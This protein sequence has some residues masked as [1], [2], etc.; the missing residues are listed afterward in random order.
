MYGVLFLYKIVEYLNKN[1]SILLHT[2]CRYILA[3]KIITISVKKKKIH[4]SFGP[5]KK[6]IQ[7]KNSNKT[8]AYITT[9]RTMKTTI[10]NKS[11]TYHKLFIINVKVTY[12]STAQ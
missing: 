8:I 1:K 7:S 6:K 9:R 2:I 10:R 5:D 3:Y 12:I 4:I 11:K